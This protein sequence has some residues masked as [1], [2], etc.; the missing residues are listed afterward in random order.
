MY[1]RVPVASLLILLLASAAVAQDRGTVDPKPLP[2][3]ANPDDPKTPAKELFGRKPSR[4]PLAG[5]RDR[6]L[7]A[8]LPRRRRRA[9]DQRQDLAG[10]AAVAQPQLGPSRPDRVPG[11]ARGQGAEGSAGPASSSATWRSRAAGRC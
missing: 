6:L 8:R 5:A 3:L 7:S 9:A 4:A 1:I 11:A 10:H 2:A